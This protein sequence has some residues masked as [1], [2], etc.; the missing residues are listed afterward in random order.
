MLCPVLHPGH[1]RCTPDSSSL[2]PVQPLPWQQCW[3]LQS[4][5]Q[6]SASSVTLT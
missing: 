5:A 2:C 3:V 4:L 6:L 1:N